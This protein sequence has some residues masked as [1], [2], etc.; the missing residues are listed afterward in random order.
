[1]TRKST[2]KWPVCVTVALALFLSA[3]FLTPRNWIF[4]LPHDE[5]TPAGEDSA[6]AHKWLVLSPE[7]EIIILPPKIPSTS[8][9]RSHLPETPKFSDA[10]WWR[11]D[12]QIRIAASKEPGSRAGSWQANRDS[13]QVLLKL[14]SA[15]AGN[16]FPTAQDSSLAARLFAM[17]VAEGFNFD[18]WKPTL[19]AWA[20]ADK[21]SDIMSRAA[22]MYGDFL[23]QKIMV[24]D[25]PDVDEHSP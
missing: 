2:L 1:M 18:N 20:R 6:T 25:E 23:Q 24:P 11:N 9:T 15:P 16:L 21:V 3:V 19:A 14:L 12:V 17:E 8:L 7:P 4:L 22:D 13:T 5:V 10:D